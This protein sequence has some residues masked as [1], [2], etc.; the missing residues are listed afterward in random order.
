[1]RRL[2][3]RVYGKIRR[4]GGCVVAMR[5][6]ESVVG[7][8]REDNRRPAWRDVRTQAGVD[9]KKYS[10][11]YVAMEVASLSLRASYERPR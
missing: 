4:S 10:P 5:C 1:M 2:A 3:L 7:N 9:K 11:D 6:D 8:L